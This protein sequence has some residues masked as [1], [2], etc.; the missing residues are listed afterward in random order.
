[1]DLLKNG[2]FQTGLKASLAA[3]LVVAFVYLV[4]FKAWGIFQ[5]LIVSIFLAGA[6]WPWISRV[7]SIAVG[8][9]K[10]R[11]PRILVTAL[12]YTL[13]LGS[14]ILVVWM[15][16]KGVLP[17]AD[18]LLAA[19]PQQT[20]FVREYLAPFQAGDIAGGAARVAEEVARG[21]TSG[22]QGATE[23]APLALAAVSV[24]ALAVALFGGLVT[25]GL[26]LIFTFF[27][28]LEGDR[29]AQWVLLTLP[30][31]RRMDARMLGLEIRDRVSRWVFA[32]FTYA[33]VSFVLMTAGMLVLQIPNPWIYGIIST[34][35]ALLPG[36]GPAAAAI[37]AF[38]V[39]LEMST[40]QAVA[41]GVF[42]VAVYALDGSV[43][44]PRIYGSVMQLPMFVVLVATLLGFE[45]LGVWGAML[46]A[47][48]AAAL[49]IVL[50]AW[51]RPGNGSAS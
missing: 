45:L 24:G 6:L 30:K 51:L 8:P 20:A 22:E 7:S 43:L 11:P 33:T 49:Q 5:P 16:L 39:A 9:R 31:E 42:A 47:P 36:I 32:Q 37:P 27:L 1:V 21:A 18:R 12:I 28:L 40:W 34:V 14:S 35:L 38:F 2:A 26:V 41:V 50:R 15:L 44:V 48:A 23:A 46:A 17:L 19:Y 4:F 29:F 10:W 25:V 13:T 3:V